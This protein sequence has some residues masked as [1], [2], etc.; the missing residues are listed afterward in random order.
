[1]STMQRQLIMAH[2]IAPTIIASSRAC[3][4]FIPQRKW[5][6]ILIQTDMANTSAKLEHA[7]AQSRTS[8]FMISSFTYLG[9]TALI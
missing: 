3:M 7:K 1:M 4:D 6:I 2:T 8:A 5:H 9:C